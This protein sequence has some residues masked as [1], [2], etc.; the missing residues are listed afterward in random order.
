[1][2]VTR[3]PYRIS[4]AG[5]GTDLPS[6][7][8][9]RSFGEV[10][11]IAIDRHIY[12]T[13]NEF[14]DINQTR[15]QY[16]KTE[17]VDDFSKFQ[18]PIVREVLKYFD[19]PQ[20]FQFASMSN[21]PGGT[22]LGSSSAFCVG[23]ISNVSA[24]I[25]KPISQLAAAELGCHVE[26]D[27]LGEQIGKQDQFGCAVGGLKRIVFEEKNVS[28]RQLTID[29]KLQANFE[30]HLI[31]VRVGAIRSASQILKEVQKKS[32]VNFAKL[33]EIKKLVP[34]MADYLEKGNIAMIGELLNQNWNL[35][36]TLSSLVSD[37]EI[38]RIYKYMVPKYA[39]GGKLLGAGGSGFLFFVLK[40]PKIPNIHDISKRSSKISIDHSGL[41]TVSI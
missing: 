7:Y 31:L 19:L 40:S 26:L 16:S 4:L 33:D 20:G 15:F 14:Y 22:G 8:T 38:D 23:L 32:N 35:K 18:N 9:D 41:T 24:L 1:M 6:Y 5:G 30:D 3:I 37:N 10:I 36:K 27:C 17:T 25:G 12:I 39:Y 21:V 28:V 11:S 2:F 29:R 34:E 13:S